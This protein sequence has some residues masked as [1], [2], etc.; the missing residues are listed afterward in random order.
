MSLFVCGLYR[1]YGFPTHT[2][3]ADPNKIMDFRKQ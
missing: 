1:N 2:A 3:L